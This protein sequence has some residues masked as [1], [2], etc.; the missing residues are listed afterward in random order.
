MTWVIT[1]LILANVVSVVY[2][3]SRI[4]ALAKLVMQLANAEAK[5]WKLQE[6]INAQQHLFSKEIIRVLYAEGNNK[7]REK[8]HK[9]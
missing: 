6:E 8:D 5:T 7:Q 3:C 1:A 2:Y 4:D 9:N